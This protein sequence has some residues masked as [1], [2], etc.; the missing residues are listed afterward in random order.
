MTNEVEADPP[1]REQHGA[2]EQA[3]L[4]KWRKELKELV[5][6]IDKSFKHPYE[7]RYSDTNGLR[8]TAQPLAMWEWKTSTVIDKKC[9]TLADY[10][11]IRGRLVQFV[12][13]LSDKKRVSPPLALGQLST[14]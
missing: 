5:S 1:I 11:F 7:I 10:E 14:V 4:A 8:C 9:H 3:E 2:V 12:R 13:Y 6:K